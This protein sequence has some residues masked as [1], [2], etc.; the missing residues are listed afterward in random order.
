MSDWVTQIGPT[1]E[2]GGACLI[3][4]HSCDIENLLLFQQHL[5]D[6]EIFKETTEVLVASLTHAGW[7]WLTICYG[8]FDRAKFCHGCTQSSEFGQWNCVGCAG[9]HVPAKELPNRILTLAD[10]NAKE[11]NGDISHVMARMGEWEVGHKDEENRNLETWISILRSSQLAQECGGL[12]RDRQA[13]L[14]A[15]ARLNV[16][17]VAF[18]KQFFHK[19]IVELKACDFRLDT[20]V[21]R[22]A[23]VALCEDPNL[24]NRHVGKSVFAFLLDKTKLREMDR[25]EFRA[26]L[27]SLGAFYDV[28]HAKLEPGPAVAYQHRKF[29]QEI[30]LAKATRAMAEVTL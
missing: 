11:A 3:Y 4:S 19:H 17:A 9:T 16:K 25:D 2:K 8:Y 12:P 5:A 14:Q 10:Q 1:D 28:A 13:L 30:E 21:N 7:W 15:V 26:F 6:H 24:S 29:L 27:V 20:K 23:R 22:S 18:Q